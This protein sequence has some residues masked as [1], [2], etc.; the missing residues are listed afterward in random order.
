M[1][2]AVIHV[3]DAAREQVERDIK[4]ISSESSFCAGCGSLCTGTIDGRCF[5]CYRQRLSRLFPDCNE[6]EAPLFA[7]STAGRMP[8]LIP[9]LP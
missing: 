5:A 7:L 4:T 8:L 2:A 1:N 3:S 6:R 9:V